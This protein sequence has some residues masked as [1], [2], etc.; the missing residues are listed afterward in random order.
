MAFYLRGILAKT[1]ITT[2]ICSDYPNIRSIVLQDDIYFIPI[3]DEIYDQIDLS[4]SEMTGPCSLGETFT[5]YLIT[6]SEN[7]KV[8]YIEAKYWGGIGG[9]AGCIWYGG[10]LVY[11]LVY[12]DNMEAINNVLSL[13]GIHA[14]TGK[15]E[16]DTVGLG[17]H[18]HIEDWLKEIDPDQ[19]IE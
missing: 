6:K 3:T 10:E 5:Q 16:F 1:D 14:E 12:E 8:A 13:M 15:D 19:I 17:R 11:E 4:S 7:A 9:Q 2:E 18:R